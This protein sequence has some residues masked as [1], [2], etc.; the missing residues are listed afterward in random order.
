MSNECKTQFITP[1]NGVITHRK[2][3]MSRNTAPAAPSAPA[4][5]TGHGYW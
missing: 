3:A 2:T 5:N 1:V 4:P